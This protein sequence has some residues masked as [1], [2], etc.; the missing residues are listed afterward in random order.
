MCRA[1]SETYAFQTCVSVGFEEPA[2]IVVN[3]Q[4]Q[5]GNMGVVVLLRRGRGYYVAAIVGFPRWI[6]FPQR[7]ARPGP[8]ISQ[9]VLHTVRETCGTVPTTYTP[10][11]RD[12]TLCL[13]RTS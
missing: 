2:P 5:F 6:G 3:G 7:Q 8:E 12:V 10:A 13:C 4:W 11:L 9:T 1:K